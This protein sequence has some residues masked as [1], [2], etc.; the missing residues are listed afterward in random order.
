MVKEGDEGCKEWTEL[1]VV[2]L[3][4]SNKKTKNKGVKSFEDA[5]KALVARKFII[6]PVAPLGEQD[7]KRTWNDCIDLALKILRELKESVRGQT[8][9][10]QKTFE[11]VWKNHPEL[12]ISLYLSLQQRRMLLLEILGIKSVPIRSV[13]ELRRVLNGGSGAE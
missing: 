8:I 9:E 2:A 13:E 10:T 11:K 4:K 5:E 1:S 3:N 12:Q 6:N 7:M